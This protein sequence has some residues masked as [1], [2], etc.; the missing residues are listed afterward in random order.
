MS[1]RQQKSKR[2]AGGKDASSF[3]FITQGGSSSGSVVASLDNDRSA[4]E[5]SYEADDDV[6]LEDDL[7]D[8]ARPTE[9]YIASQ[10]TNILGGLMLGLEGQRPQQPSL[11]SDAT[12]PSSRNRLGLGS[13]ITRRRTLKLATTVDIQKINS[14][15]VM[16]R[17]LSNFNQSMQEGLEREIVEMSKLENAENEKRKRQKKGNYSSNFRRLSLGVG[18]EKSNGSSLEMPLP[19]SSRRLSMFV[20]QQPPPI[21]STSVDIGDK[22]VPEKSV[23]AGSTSQQNSIDREDVATKEEKAG[24]TGE[25]NN[26]D[27]NNNNNNNDNNDNDME[28]KNGHDD[29][30][31]CNDDDNG[32]GGGGGDDDD[33]D[34]YSQDDFEEYED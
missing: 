22:L 28:D 9:E 3:E 1:P 29:N 34:E 30:E 31:K 19:E 24:E 33:D 13:P 14:S 25:D 7:P 15:L 32:G 6:F 12:S 18:F 11:A 5:D 2:R 27:T 16:D 17:R 21:S 10:G 8:V 4:A 26:D 20:E 23:P